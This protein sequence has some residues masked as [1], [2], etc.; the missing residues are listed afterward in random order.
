MSDT[1]SGNGLLALSI[2]IIG[3]GSILHLLLSRNTEFTR[4]RACDVKLRAQ[5][6]VSDTVRTL[7][8]DLACRHGVTP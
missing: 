7:R 1:R 8:T 6:T 4:E 2:I 3:L 5:P